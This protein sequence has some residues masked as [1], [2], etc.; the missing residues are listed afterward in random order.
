MKTISPNT[1]ITAR[2]IC[3]SECVFTARVIERKGQFAKL[4]IYGQ[5]VRKKINVDSQG[6]EGIYA[7]GRYSMAPW[8]N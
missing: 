4:L 8:F 2:S 7:L 3:D 5:I 6:N 1:T